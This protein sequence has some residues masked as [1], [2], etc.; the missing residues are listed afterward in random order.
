MKYEK[1]SFRLLLYWLHCHGF[2]SIFRN[3]GDSVVSYIH[4]LLL[5]F[6]WTFFLHS[7]TMNL[8]AHLRISPVYR[9]F[10]VIQRKHWFVWPGYARV[11]FK[12]VSLEESQF[13]PVITLFIL[14]SIL[15]STLLLYLKKERKGWFKTILY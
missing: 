8:Y 11:R 3:G 9:A 5:S 7:I 14:I 10:N 2:V 1:R 15:F 6:I 13:C 12:R 4:E